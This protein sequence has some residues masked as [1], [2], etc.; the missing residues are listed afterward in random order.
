MA[1]ASWLIDC[2]A[3][4]S[5]AEKPRQTDDK[6]DEAADRA[7]P[8]IGVAQTNGQRGVDD[9]RGHEQRRRR[10]RQRAPVAALSTRRRRAAATRTRGSAARQC[11]SAARSAPPLPSSAR[12]RPH[13]S[14]RARRRVVARAHRR[15][16]R[17]SAKES[18]ATAA[19]ALAATAE[20]S[21][22]SGGATRCAAHLF[23]GHSLHARK[24]AFAVARCRR[25]GRRRRR[26]FGVHAN[27]LDRQ[28]L[29]RA[30]SGLAPATL[31][32]V[33]TLVSVRTDAACSCAPT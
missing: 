28:S 1:V 31:P 13:E 21:N 10:R 5:R 26:L 19:R 12:R 15:R 17:L 32:R 30:V 33:R 7:H 24:R 3:K 2:G 9:E 29:R 16:R 23:L 4:A 25:G 18:G 11:K 6:D 22:G 14:A 8:Q 27:A 20:R